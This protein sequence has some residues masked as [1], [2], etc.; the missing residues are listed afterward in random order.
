MSTVSTTAVEATFV[1]EARALLD[2]ELAV[3]AGTVSKGPDTV[4]VDGVVYVKAASV[5]NLLDHRADTFAITLLV[6]V[7]AGFI[8]GLWVA[9]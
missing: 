5:T 7:V 9:L 6:G 3:I 8:A 4:L 2:T 1:T